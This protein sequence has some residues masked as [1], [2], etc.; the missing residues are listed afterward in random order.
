MINKV[1]E[2]IGVLPIAN[3]DFGNAIIDINIRE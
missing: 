3:P 1:I 2:L